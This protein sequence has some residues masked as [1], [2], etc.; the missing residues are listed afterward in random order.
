LFTVSFLPQN[1]KVKVEKGTSLLEAVSLAKIAI[2][3]LCGGEGI[4]GRC[5]MIVKKGKVSGGVSGKLTRDE[6]KKGFV[7]ACMA[8]VE[9]DI[10]AEIPKETLAKEK[11]GADKDADYFTDFKSLDFKTKYASS[12][13]ISKVYLKLKKPTLTNNT[14]DHQ[15]VFEE[16]KR[17][18]KESIEMPLEVIKS[19]PEILRKN[20][21]CITATVG[22][23]GDITEVINIEGGDTTDKSYMAV[24]DI[25]TT[26]VVAHLVK[27]DTLK[28]IETEACFNSQGIYGR[29]VT[30]RMINAEKKGSENLQRLIVEDINRLITALVKKTRID[31]KDINAVVCSGNTAMSH[32]LLNLSTHNIRRLPYIAASVEPPPLRASSIGI[33]INSRGLLYFLPGISGWVGSDLTSGILATGMHENK[34][35]SLLV[36]IGTNGEIIIGNKEWL[37]A[38]SASAGPALEGASVEC[39]MRAESGAIEIVY[40]ENKE[41]KYKTIGNSTPK[42]ICGSGIL[43]LISILLQK[44]I[45]DRSG[46][47][48][49]RSS[50]RIIS[51]K[52]SKRFVLV[53]KDKTYNKK[54]VFITEADIEN[55][56]TAK[57]AIYAA[58][59][60]ILKRLDLKFYHIYHFY[61]AGA[62]GSHLNIENVINIGLIPNIPQNRIHFVGNTSI[63]G[64]KIAACY[65]DAFYKLTEIRKNTTYYDLLGAK[66]YVEEFKKAMFLPHTDVES[67]TTV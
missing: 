5:K 43:D 56:I 32:F 66:D 6:I 7:L 60:I 61:I 40:I 24:V 58:M 19:L 20:K 47:F 27:A 34:K 14:A 62:F 26:T 1:K 21:F 18:K 9:Q 28:T 31:L 35:L 2:N 10:V 63:R 39:G 49:E 23:R 8:L 36:D 15:R 12:P 16:I 55:V 22:L 59:K 13:L 44:E 11:A 37:M 46:K 38:C 30:G 67:F 65:K 4:C 53:D 51:V 48:I 29:E 33:K 45:I 52:G 64:A 3:N 25:G 50:P 57:A 17:K 41:I 54:S 42:G